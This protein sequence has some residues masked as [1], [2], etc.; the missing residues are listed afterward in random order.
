M[1]NGQRLPLA[2]SIAA[3]VVALLGATPLGEAAGER[4]M[5]VVPFAKTAGYAKVAGTAAKLN[6]HRST[7]SGAPNT[8]PVVGRNG[9]LPV[10]LGAV[11]PQGPR[12]EP[13]PAGPEG[14]RGETGPKG[15]PGPVGP[16]GPRGVSGWSFVTK[17]FTVAPKKIVSTTVNCPAGTKAFGGGVAHA[18]LYDVDTHI[19]NDAPGGQAT[20]WYVTIWNDGSANLT[21]SYYVW[22][23]CANVG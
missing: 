8:I 4:V 10:A 16:P 12:G 1:L 21:L 2:L 19:L 17:G 22:A 7:L 23:I 3:F 13:G 5:A 14:P 6:G 18:H 9:K 11:G 15:P 20:G